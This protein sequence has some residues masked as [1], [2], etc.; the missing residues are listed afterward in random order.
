MVT[1]RDISV[2]ALRGI[3]IV[4]MI[5]AN[6]AAL[7]LIQPH[8]LWLRLYGSF[9]APL[10]ILVS[11]MMVNYTTS[12]KG[13]GLRHFAGRGLMIIA[14][15]ALVD[16]LIWKIYPFTT[17][18]VLYLIGI[19]LPLA[20]IFGRL[21]TPARWIIIAA[22]F[23]ATPLLQ[24][25][26]G[27]TD[28]P[29]EFNLLGQSTVIVSD[30]TSILNHWLVDGWFPIFP[31]IGFIFLGDALA[32]IRRNSESKG[33]LGRGRVLLTGLVLLVLG[34]VIWMVYPGSLLVR[35]GYSELFYPPTIG[36][37]VTA[38]GFAVTL[39]G[40]VD[41]TA[42]SRVYRPFQTMGRSSLFIYILHLALVEYL[43]ALFISPLEIEAYVVA[44]LVMLATVI[45]AAYLVKAAKN[46]RKLRSHALRFL[47]GS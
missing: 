29:T 12:T 46:R 5:A 10:F 36:Y 37:V 26:F 13:Y 40:L 15:G 23:L 28:Y 11:G 21:K 14:V 20:Y 35:A 44:Y 45:V 30:Q 31:W 2:D 1:D 25:L 18:D 19:S 34:I 41:R 33:R 9:A 39:F 24:I 3:G 6:M 47:L 42:S 4:I 17:F 43:F 38:T 16:V 7:L 22:I 8:P 32:G 27:Y